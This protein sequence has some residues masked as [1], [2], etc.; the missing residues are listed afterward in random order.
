MSELDQSP[1]SAL[2]D[3]MPKVSVVSCSDDGIEE[4]LRKAVD[5]VDGLS[6]VKGRKIVSIKP[7][8]CQPNSAFSLQLTSG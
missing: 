3:Q 8:L 2:G 1:K 7:N 6:N 5:L 4:G